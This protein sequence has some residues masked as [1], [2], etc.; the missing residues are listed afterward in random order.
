MPHFSCDLRS[1]FRV[2]FSA[3]GVRQQ[4]TTAVRGEGDSN[5]EGWEF[6]RREAAK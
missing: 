2:R 4:E 3:K 6:R 5:R 1:E